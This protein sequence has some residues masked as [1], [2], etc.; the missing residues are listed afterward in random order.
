MSPDRTAD[1]R[2]DVVSIHLRLPKALH[3]RLVREAKSHSV[4]LNTEIVHQLEHVS[5]ALE[6]IQAQITQLSEKM[7]ARIDKID[8]ALGA[9]PPTPAL[10]QMMGLRADE[11][12]D[13]D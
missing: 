8:R 4:S 3:R 6:G 5:P 11:Q 13:K 10:E 7:T 9:E 12:K 2:P 1:T